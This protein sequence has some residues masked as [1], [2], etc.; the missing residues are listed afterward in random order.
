L[1]S[2]DFTNSASESIHTITMTIDGLRTSTSSST[3][4]KCPEWDFCNKQPCCYTLS[5]DPDYLADLTDRRRDPVFHRNLWTHFWF[6]SARTTV[7]AEEAATYSAKFDR[8]QR[9]EVKRK[10]IDK[11]VDANVADF[12]KSLG[13]MT[14]AESE[15]VLSEAEIKVIRD[16]C[17]QRLKSNMAASK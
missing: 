6:P 7:S 3:H 13:L 10:Q 16:K 11:E 2:P 8:C 14:E 9:L 15:P 1:I 12:M 5:L 4:H 17:V